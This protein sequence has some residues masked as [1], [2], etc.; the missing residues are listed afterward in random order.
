MEERQAQEGTTLNDN[1]QREIQRIS[2]VQISKGKLATG[3]N[4]N[5]SNLYP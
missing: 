2:K 1:E 5:D 4:S 3:N